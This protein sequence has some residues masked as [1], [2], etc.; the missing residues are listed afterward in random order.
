M[1]VGLMILIRLQDDLGFDRFHPHPARTYRITSEYTKKNGEHWK[2]ASSPLPLRAVLASDTNTIEEAV[3]IYP[4]LNGNA[5]AGGKEINLHAAFTGP[6]FFKV[7]GFSLAAGDPVTA[8]QMPNTIVIS[9]ST[10]QKFFGE[11]NPLGK[12]VSL[13]HGN[14]FLVTGVLKENPGKSHLD[15]DAYASYASVTG[16]E[17]NGTLST[18]TNNWYAFNAAYTY[19]LLKKGVRDAYLAPFLRS[20]ADHLNRNNK[21]GHAAFNMQALGKIT[22]ADSSLDNEIGRGAPWSKIFFEIG[23]ALMIL[24]AACF[25]YTNLT[26]AR[27]LTRAKEVGLRK[28]MGAKRYHVFAQYIVEST[29]LAFVAL[30][31]A[32]MLLSFILEYAPFNDGYEFIPSSFRYNFSFILASLGFTV[33]TGLLAGA[34]PAWILS[35]FKPIRVLKNLSTARILG[36]VSIQ[37]TLIVFQ[38]S[39]SL[40]MIIFLFAFYRQFAFLASADPGFKRD[41]IV[42][43]PLAGIDPTIASARIGGLSGVVS[44]AAMSS[45]FDQHFSGMYF[46]SHLDNTGNSIKMRSYYADDRFIPS[47]KF[48]WVAGTNFPAHPSDPRERYIVLNEQAALALGFKDYHKAIGQKLWIDDSTRLEITGILKDFVYENAGIRIAPLAFRYKPVA[49]NYLYIT[50]GNGNKE[51][52]TARIAN[53]WKGLSGSPSFDYSWLDEALDKSNSQKATI[54]LLG[55]LAFMAVAIAIL[56]LLG[57]VTYTVE[58]KRKEISIRKV[59]GADPRQ[60]ILLLSKGFIRLLFL[61][62]LIATPIG[63]A[64]G[65]LFSQNF[66]QRP[67]YGPSQ[68]I[69]CFLF[70]LSIGL[71]TI[72]SQTAKAAIENPVQHLR[73]E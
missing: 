2:M 17:E 38:Y 73:T 30:A 34:A 24:L 7:F 37:K 22:P 66:A 70:L 20:V 49:C 25:N 33:F 47:L 35:A 64:A 48:Q 50:T 16:M 21:E 9:H 39:L 54:S 3:N 6:S 23:I 11:T 43:V 36:R 65:Y 15:F 28:I 59:I 68:A 12:V 41:N 42:V 19:V 14:N 18:Q 44:V 5:K 57:L 40:V 31:F 52:V 27:S 13:E 69:A 46:T 53:A 55:Y 60:L 32:W 4:A 63:Y 67:A 1:S 58:V 8:L 45:R 10:A 56:G 71:F 29:L 72:I 62:G 51:A 26:I 61:A